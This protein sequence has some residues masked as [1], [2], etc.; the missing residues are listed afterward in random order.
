MINILISSFSVCVR[1]LFV[2]CIKAMKCHGV[3]AKKNGHTLL[4]APSVLNWLTRWSVSSPREKA[5]LSTYYVNMKQ[6]SLPVIRN[7]FFLFQ[8][9]A[10]AG[11]C[12]RKMAD[13]DLASGA[14]DDL[15]K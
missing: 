8:T 4:F 14:P 9:P 1:T 13:D 6:P 12:L 15:Y 10:R 3:I 7:S 11:V 5:S 2:Q